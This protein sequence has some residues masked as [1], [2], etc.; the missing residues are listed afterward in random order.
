MQKILLLALA[1]VVAGCKGNPFSSASKEPQAK[2]GGAVSS[3]N[4]AAIYCERTGGQPDTLKDKDGNEYGI[5]RL[6]DGQ[7]MDEW[8]YLREH[9]D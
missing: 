9:G 2:A 3:G 8:R 4:P 5:C 7:I 1:A 6:P